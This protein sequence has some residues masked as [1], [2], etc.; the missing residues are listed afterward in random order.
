MSEH[1]PE[2]AVE[3]MA[4]ALY[5]GPDQYGRPSQVTWEDMLTYGGV[6]P[7]NTEHPIAEN[8]RTMA[9]SA[10]AA[11]LP[12][13]V[14][15][16]SVTRLLAAIDNGPDD[17]GHTDAYYARLLRAALGIQDKQGGNE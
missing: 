6:F 8:F 9:R 10:L 4:K 2:A 7:G 14:T 12:H 15:N 11:A 3:A 1:I 16:E 17:S 13:L 5:E